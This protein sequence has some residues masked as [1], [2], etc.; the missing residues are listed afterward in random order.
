MNL[1]KIK[2]KNNKKNTLPP[3]LFRIKYHYIS[4]LKYAY[5]KEKIVYLDHII[6]IV[7]FTTNNIF[8]TNFIIRE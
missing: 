5:T 3:F 8:T 2:K 7:N 1:T 4:M 6:I